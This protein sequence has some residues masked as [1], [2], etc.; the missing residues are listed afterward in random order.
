MPWRRTAGTF[1]ARA[2]QRIELPVSLRRADRSASTSIR[3]D[4]AVVSSAPSVG[5]R[6][7]EIVDDMGTSAGHRAV[8][9]EANSVRNVGADD[10][11]HVLGRTHDLGCLLRGPPRRVG[12]MQDHFGAPQHEDPGNLGTLISPQGIIASRPSGVS[13]TGNI[14]AAQREIRIHEI[15]RDGKAVLTVGNA[16]SSL[17]DRSESM[18]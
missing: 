9:R 8:E 12:R 3:A 14:S 2:Q 4:T 17:R 1:P 7:A 10:E 15:V 13:A 11:D 16:R 6:A 5:E 18:Y